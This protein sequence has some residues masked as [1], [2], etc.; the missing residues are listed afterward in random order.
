[1]VRVTVVAVGHD[2]VECCDLEW[3]V[4][5]DELVLELEDELERLVV[6]L[7]L[8]PCPLLG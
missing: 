1:M 2:E 4:D 6:E 8:V 3:L 5:V 7:E